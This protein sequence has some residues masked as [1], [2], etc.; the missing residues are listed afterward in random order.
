MLP[1]VLGLSGFQ[2][3]GYPGVPAE[4]MQTSAPVVAKAPVAKPTTPKPAAKPAGRPAGRSGGADYQALARQIAKEVGVPEDL[5]LRLIA[6]ESAWNINAKSPVGASGLAQLMPGTARGLGVKNIWDPVENM[7]GGARYLKAQYDRYKRWDYALAAYNAGPGNVNKY[8]GIPPFK[9]TR[10]YVA[11]IMR[12]WQPPSAAPRPLSTGKD[13]SNS[14][15]QPGGVIPAAA[16]APAQGQ[17]QMPTFSPMPQ[18][19]DPASMPETLDPSAI[20][21]PELSDWDTQIEQLQGRLKDLEGEIGNRVGKVADFQQQQADMVRNRTPDAPPP[22]ADGGFNGR[23]ALKALMGAVVL[24]MAGLKPDE[25]ETGVNAYSRTK[26]GRAQNEYAAKVGETRSKQQREEDEI[27]ALGIE[28]QAEGTRIPALERRVTDVGND[29]AKFTEKGLVQKEARQKMYAKVMQ[30][31]NSNASDRL[32]AMKMFELNGGVVP[33]SLKPSIMQDG[34]NVRKW[35]AQNELSKSRLDLDKDKFTA[36]K[37]QF[38]KRLSFDERKLKQA[39]EQHTK[40]L[41]QRWEIY[42]KSREY[43][44][45]DAALKDVTKAFNDGMKDLDTQRGKLAD[46]KRDRDGLAAQLDVAE[47]TAGNDKSSSQERKSAKE[48]AAKLREEIAGANAIIKSMDA[49]LGE[50]E[51]R[52]KDMKP[53]VRQSA[54]PPATKA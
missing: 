36:Q 14:Q 35:M 45:T 17:P 50:F 32:V 13:L 51:A 26:V 52:L 2:Q 15:P 31:P 4:V 33:A 22:P 19:F 44:E 16:P 24:R 39:Q 9:E 43:K 34:P 12:G 48:R 27:K 46:A 38:R 11:K 40:T 7:R 37:D 6:A 42:N 29:I 53:P 47:R 54:T 1:N 25:I 18:T 41:T 10:N 30:D 28:A 8:N 3:Q 23:D 5:F 21:D 49:D 20:Q